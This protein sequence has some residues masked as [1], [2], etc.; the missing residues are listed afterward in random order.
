MTRDEFMAKVQQRERPQRCEA[1]LK[2]DMLERGKPQ[3]RDDFIP[4]P[5]D[6]RFKKDENGKYVKFDKAE[7]L[8][9]GMMQNGTLIVK[10]TIGRSGVQN[11]LTGQEI[12]EDKEVFSR[13]HLATLQN[14]PVTIGHGKLKPDKED[15][16]GYVRDVMRNGRHIEANI[17]INDPQTIK[18]VQNGLLSGFS[19]GYV[20]DDVVKGGETYQTNLRGYHLALLPTPSHSRCGTSC[21]IVD[22]KVA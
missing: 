4:H 11:Y 7:I 14:L 9:G 6:T 1:K 20:S 8:H 2:A 12:R 18:E 13:E 22:L 15:T 16:V 3:Y 10:A 5:L 19:L 17:E 21:K